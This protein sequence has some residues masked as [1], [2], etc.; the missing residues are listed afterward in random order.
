MN[1]AAQLGF[2]PAQIVA[3]TQGNC[4]LIVMTA[5]AGDQAER[6]AAPTSTSE[7]ELN[8]TEDSSLS[9]SL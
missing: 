9:T 3:C 6:T 5:L 8:D 1:R 7:R 4:S 2:T